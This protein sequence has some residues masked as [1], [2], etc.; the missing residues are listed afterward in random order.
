MGTEA[1][2]PACLSLRSRKVREGKKRAL[3]Y[4]GI[5]LKR[6]SVVFFVL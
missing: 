3:A 1:M 4:K 6:E 2:E 5:R